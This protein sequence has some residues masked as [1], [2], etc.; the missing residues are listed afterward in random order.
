MIQL[1]LLPDIK[2]EYI[3]AARTKKM[4]VVLSILA[5]LSVVGVVSLISFYTFVVRG[6]HMKNLN[7]DIQTK[8]QELASTQDI[9]KILTVQN[10][11]LS[12]PALHDEKPRTSAMFDY[13][14]QLTP[15]GIALSDLEINF[16]DGT[17]KLTGEADK[18][19]TLNQFVDTI[20]FTEMVVKPKQDQA[21]SAQQQTEQ[22]EQDVEAVTSNAFSE[23]VLDSFSLEEDIVS[24]TVVFKFDPLIFSNTHNVALNISS[25]FSTRSQVE[26]PIFEAPTQP[27]ETGEA[28]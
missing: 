19:P 21:S 16:E 7:E 25:K 5:S 3:K 8:S 28:E 10:Q 14:S 23:V 18:L 11:L 26:K 27:K 24:F 6:T 15:A 22:E 20:K 12:L 13:L 4:V 9:D 1:N 17:I 2:L